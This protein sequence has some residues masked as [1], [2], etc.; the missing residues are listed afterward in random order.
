MSF[1]INVTSYLLLKLMLF[2]TK[3]ILYQFHLYLGHFIMMS[4]RT[5]GTLFKYQLETNTLEYC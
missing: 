4:F 2:H 1:H 3:V 5:T